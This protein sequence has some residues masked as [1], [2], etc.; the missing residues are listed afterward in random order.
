MRR[1]RRPRA[2]AAID[3]RS[4]GVTQACGTSC[5]RRRRPRLQIG[6]PATGAHPL[7][8]ASIVAGLA[9]AWVVLPRPPASAESCAYFVASC[10]LS[11]AHATRA[12]LSKPT[13]WAPS[14]RSTSIAS[15]AEPSNGP[16]WC[17]PTAHRRL[18]TI[19]I[20]MLG[21]VGLHGPFRLHHHNVVSSGNGKRNSLLLG[22]VSRCNNEF[23]E[24]LRR[25][26][27]NQLHE[28]I[29]LFG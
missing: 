13:L 15:R 22:S 3:R 6:A 7:P 20:P 18:W 5:R 27:H 8:L 4:A 24:H 26:E 16:R 10:V 11:C 28:P 12:W 2:W 21:H 1:A 25:R 23:L 9:D 17:S 29:A 19:D 14:G